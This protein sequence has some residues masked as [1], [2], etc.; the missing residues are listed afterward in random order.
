MLRIF[1][2]RRGRSLFKMDTRTNGVKVNKLKVGAFL[3]KKKK[4]Q[5]THRASCTHIYCLVSMFYQ[6]QRRRRIFNNKEGGGEIFFLTIFGHLIIFSLKNF[7]FVSILG[8]PPSDQCLSFK[9]KKLR[10]VMRSIVFH[11]CDY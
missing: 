7:L 5:H 9:K 6:H 4:I 1:L 8:S 3:S 11:R 2:L 10:L